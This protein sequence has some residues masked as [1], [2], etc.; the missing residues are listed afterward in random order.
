MVNTVTRS[1]TRNTKGH[2][3]TSTFPIPLS[4][5]EPSSFGASQL[6][7]ILLE[8][9]LLV[10]TCLFWLIVLP[11]SGA[12]CATVAVYDKIMAISA[13]RG[14]FFDLRYTA[15]RNPLVLSRTAA[16]G[17]KPA[18]SRPGTQAAKA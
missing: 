3:M 17:S 2:L 5:E 7:A 16:T 6:K 15:A 8:P 9:L 12:F 10:A 18:A 14:T 1:S 13:P 11:I 4:P